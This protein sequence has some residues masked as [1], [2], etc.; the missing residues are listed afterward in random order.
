MKKT[1]NKY[2][3]LAYG[4]YFNLLAAIS[5]QRAAAK[6]FRLFCTPRKGKVRPEQHDFL[7]QAKSRRL[8][9]ANE[10]I[11]TYHWQGE[12]ETVLLLHGWESNAFRWRN[13]ITFLKK[14]SYNIVAFDAPAHGH[15]TGAI[16]NVPLYTE[17]TKVVA[18][19]YKP[20]IV[21]GHSVGGMNTLYHQEKYPNEK[22]EKIIT[23]GS[24]SRLQDIMNDYQR[25]LKFNDKVLNGLDDHFKA[26]FGFGIADFST[27]NF[28]GHLSKKGLIIHDEE[29]AIAPFSASESVHKTWKNSS[30]F[31]TKGL[32]HS[33]H[34]DQVNLHIMDFIRS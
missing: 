14:E 25:I 4:S 32:G 21:I 23:I 1:I 34:Q 16:L 10:E 28:K 27:S 13:L 2:L 3:P 20:K 22:I 18:D 31:R 15:S 24:P 7:E 30:F 12:N 6:A 5:K 9:A 26:L 19:T 8:K 17:C 29:D 11:Q 33:M